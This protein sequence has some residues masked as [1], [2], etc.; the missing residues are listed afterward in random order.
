MKV[1]KG[2]AWTDGIPEVRLSHLRA[3]LSSRDCSFSVLRP[4][5]LWPPDFTRSAVRHDVA[6]PSGSWGGLCLYEVPSYAALLVRLLGRS[7]IRS[8]Q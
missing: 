5:A 7:G 6:I 4:I 3:P 2:K 8:S 1:I